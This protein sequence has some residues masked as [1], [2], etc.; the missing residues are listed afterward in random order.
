MKNQSTSQYGT[1]VAFHE[2]PLNKDLLYVGTDDGLIQVSEDGG[3]NWRKKGNFSGVPANTY[4]NQIIASQ[5]NENVVYA[6]FNDHKRGNFQPYVY[7]SVDKG[8]TWQN[9]TNNLPKKGTVYTIAEDYVDNN[10]LFVGNEY[11]FF[12]TNNGGG[13]WKKL[14]NGLP[15]V[16][17]RDMA[18][19]QRENDLVLATFGRG[20]YV[21]DDYSALR[22]TS[23]EMLAKEANIFPIEPGI[24]FMEDTPMGL[25]GKSFQGDSYF[26]TENP[27][28]GASFTYYVK[29][30]YKSLKE[31]RLEKDKKAVKAGQDTPYPSYEELEAE[32]KE[33]TAYL[34]FTIRDIN[35]EV[36]RTIKK[37]VKKGIHRI[38]WDGRI[39]Y[40]GP[41]SLSKREGSI[42]G[43][44]AETSFLAMPGTYNISLAK[45]ANG[46]LT[47]LVPPTSFLLKS[48]GG[49][50]LRADNVKE[51]ADF[52]KDVAELQ[53]K[54][55]GTT[56]KISEVS[57][58]LKHIRK[59]I[60]TMP[61][62]VETLEKDLLQVEDNLSTIRKSFYGDRLK[63][64]LDQP[65]LTPLG[66]RI[67]GATA[68]FDSTSEPTTTA[69]DAYAIAQKALKLEVQN[70]KNL[71]QQVEALEAKLEKAGAPY[72]P[73]RAIDWKK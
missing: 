69:K 56:R 36:I 12:F 37:P 11:S 8:A 55:M 38:L 19:Q 33:E 62:P 48:L 72:T 46:K 63:S 27:P 18:I 47:E 7:K 28:V 9:I 67:W 30:S 15:T 53:R 49:T 31:Q 42:F 54:F 4:V 6:C 29:E 44:P 70:I 41:V 17:V 66:A 45:S 32:Q 22:S 35:E 39:A 26:T 1:I 61:A 16:A 59:A 13:H 2:S 21:L 40:P 3:A 14:A 52:H 51:L 58:Q 68:G 23:K 25:R 34:L 50:T 65:T 24:I 5:H 20:F 57:N 60:Y 43:P 73:G 71:L 64:R 10:L